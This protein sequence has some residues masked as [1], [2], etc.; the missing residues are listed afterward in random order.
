MAQRERGGMQ[1]KS[2]TSNRGRTRSRGS[3]DGSM[4][5]SGSMGSEERE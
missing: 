2:K 5:P 1:R 3:Q 4:R